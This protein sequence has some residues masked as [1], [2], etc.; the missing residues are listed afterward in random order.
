MYEASTA[1]SAMPAQKATFVG[2]RAYRR[3]MYG[4]HHPLAIPRVS[5]TFDLIRAFGAL[6]PEEFLS[7]REA[8]VDELEGF[9]TPEY[10]HAVR[11]SEA[12]G[13]VPRAWRA[14]HGLGT[15]ENP[16]FDGLFTLPAR[17]AGASIQA[18]EALL[19]GRIAFNPAGGMHHAR[20]N[21]ARGFCYFNDPV[22]AIL[23]LRQAGLRVLYVDIDA[24]H[25]DGVESAFW[26]D[27]SVL[28]LSLHMDSRHAYPFSGGRF[29]DAGA[30][31]AGFTTLNVPLPDGVNDA[32]YALVFDAAWAP[33][34]RRFAPDAVVLQA[35]TDG[36]A[37]DP[38]GKFRLSTQG[39]LET[40]AK[41]MSASPRHAD[42]TPCLMVTGG[43]GYHP[44]ALA[45]AWAGLWGL[46]SGRCLPHEIPEKGRACL[47][48]VPW[49]R[50]EEEPAAGRLF[51]SRIDEPQERTIRPEIERLAE[52][53]AGHPF[54]RA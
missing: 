51:A 20:A 10:V 3:S 36:L 4:A 50:D 33:A 30:P 25:G 16:Y 52:R 7:A 13:R 14:R 53:I 23:R 22:L 19:N 31:G 37:L 18:A 5:L 11:R 48:A 49:D 2:S 54:L 8:T 35:G 45:R 15:S 28:T 9:H 34:N 26:R 32:E 39:F 41:V 27:D 44:L 21:Q 24:H 42:G 40:A 6:E 12:L 17:A 47:Q 29:E 38:L 43:G 46:L 1:P